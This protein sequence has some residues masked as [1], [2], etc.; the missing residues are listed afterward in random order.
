MQLDKGTGLRDWKKALNLSQNEVLGLDIGSSS[1]KIV[2]MRKNGDGYRVIAAGRVDISSQPPPSDSGREINTIRAIRECVRLTDVQTRWAVCGVCGPEVAVRSFRFPPMPQQEIEGAVFLEASQLCPFNVED[3]A[4]DYQLIN[5]GGSDVGGVMVAATGKMIET[6]RRLA[7][8]AS[9]ETVLM[10][11]D[12][13][14]LLNC[15]GQYER[16]QKSPQLLTKQGQGKNRTTAILNVGSSYTILAVIGGNNLPFIRDIAFAG[17]NIIGQI[18]EEMNI[19]ATTVVK[20]LT[21]E[22]GPQPGPVAGL[23]VSLQKA[24]EKLIVDTGETLRYY[25]AQEKA[26]G[27][28]EKI[29][30]CGGFAL[31]KGFVE[32]LEKGLGTKVILWNPFDKIPLQAGQVDENVIGRYGPALAVAAGL[33]MR[34]I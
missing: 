8:D 7:R 9:L 32:L 26:G 10:D 20:M 13:L 23:D 22:A 31:V 19:S 24:C 16:A 17:S 30:V 15:F 25:A 33:A 12:G 14:A 2:Q 11:V 1:V 21:A 4:V 28:V 27:F 34:T 29:F 18:S 6:K 3:G 5:S